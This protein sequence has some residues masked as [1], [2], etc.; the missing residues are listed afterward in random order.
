MYSTNSLVLIF[1]ETFTFYKKN[2]S[3]NYN[4]LMSDLYKS[5]YTG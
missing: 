2:C 5:C 4:V 3:L 1:S